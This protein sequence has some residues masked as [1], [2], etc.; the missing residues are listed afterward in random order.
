[1]DINKNQQVNTFLK[2][3]NTDISDSL[4]DSSQYRYAENLRLITNTDSNSG[5]LRLIEGT[6]EILKNVFSGESIIYIGSIRNYLYVITYKSYPIPTISP[7]WSIYVNKDYGT[8]DFESGFRCI[9]GP[10]ETP[11]WK[12][13]TNIALSTETRWE[14]DNNIKLYIADNTSEHG[15]ISINIDYDHWPSE[16]NVPSDIK[17][18]T[19]YQNMFLQAPI[20]NISQYAGNIVPAKVQYAY[21]LYKNGGAASSISTLS[22]VLSIYKT[23]KKGYSDKEISNKAVDI[24]INVHDIVGLNSI[25]IYRISYIQNGQQPTVH[26]IVNEKNTSF[27]FTYVDRGTNI[28]QISMSELLGMIQNPIQPQIIE[29]KDDYLF[30]ANLS[31]NQDYVDKKIKEC[32]FDAISVS[33]GNYWIDNNGDRQDIQ[34]NSQSGKLVNKLEDGWKLCHDQFDGS[35]S[36]DYNETYW[37]TYAQNVHVNNYVVDGRNYGGTGSN[38]SWSYITDNFITLDVNSGY[39]QKIM[40]SGFKHDETYRFGIIL[41]DEK[42]NQSSVNWIADIRIPS[43]CAKDQGNNSNYT[44]CPFGNDIIITPTYDSNT[45][46]TGVQYSVR[47]YGIKFTVR[48]LPDWCSGFQIVRCPRTL[49]DSRVISQGITY[50]PMRN[51]YGSSDDV[52]F[53]SSDY[54]TNYIAPSGFVTMQ[55]SVARHGMYFPEEKYGAAYSTDNVV[56]FA[57]PEYVYQPDDIKDILD[58][59]SN[60][61]NIEHVASY[62][63]FSKYY[64]GY[65]SIETWQNST[66][67]Y[68]LRL[69]TISAANNNTEIDILEWRGRD[70]SNLIKVE[71]VEDKPGYI[72]FNHVVPAAINNQLDQDNE[73]EVVTYPE[74]KRTAFPEVPKYNSFSDGKNITFRNASTTLGSDEFINWSYAPYLQDPYGS[75]SSMAK[76]LS[77]YHENDE[78]GHFYYPIG[79]G[80][81]CILF[82]FNEKIQFGTTSKSNEYLYKPVD[83]ES[84]TVYGHVAPIHIAN[85]VKQVYPY[86]GYNAHAINNSSYN[87]YGDVYINTHEPI[88]AEITSGDSYASLFVYNA[89]HTWDDPKYITATQNATVCIV[90]IESDIDLRASYGD[91]YDPN[92]NK[93]YYFQ[94]E[95]VSFKG[96]SQTKP[97]Y[98]YNTAYNQIPNVVTLSPAEYTDISSNKFDTRIHYSQ[99]KTNGESIDNW[100]QFKALDFI[101]VDSKFGEITQMQLFKNKLIFWQDESIGML[102]VND[103]TIINSTDND[104]IVLG[105]TGILQRY[106]YISTK[107]GMKPYQFANAQSDTTLYWWDGYAKELLGFDSQ[108]IIPL[109]TTKQIKNYINSGEE[110]TRPSLFYDAKY[111]ELVSHIL[112]KN[113][114]VYNEQIQAFTSIYGN[115]VFTF[116]PTV[117][118][119]INNDILLCAGN[120]IY[121]YNDSDVEGQAFLFDNVA[122]PYLK[123]IVNNQ[124]T[125]NKVFDITTFGGN[126]YG[127]EDVLTQNNDN[128]HLVIGEFDNLKLAPLQ[129]KFKTSLNQ[130]GIITG[131]NITNREC[132]YRFDIPRD[133]FKGNTNPRQYF[134]SSEDWGNRLRGKIMQCELTS[135]SN[136]T[137]FSLQYIITK[138]RMSWS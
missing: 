58:T 116:N 104:Q 45:V 65:S 35:S 109:S 6:K 32:G 12:D 39:D 60:N 121:R 89:S 72:A 83:N 73:Q 122:R 84:Y 25:E 91:L 75:D 117:N 62:H 26:M 103:K 86:G 120:S 28:H 106:D 42:G 11:I 125:N 93:G 130:T 52:W 41:Y 98:Q 16:T 34:I 105:G 133:N 59:Y 70:G 29:S 46:L 3:M 131:S 49:Q 55:K 66:N 17:V 94:D 137:D 56:C 1:M 101:D 74:I 96:Y 5:E 100:L 21:R 80:G 90:P 36:Y 132:D 135:S 20:V 126:I 138:Y 87:Q 123:Y 118:T 110:A 10:C 78:Y 19:G 51:L 8:N 68:R 37:H 38:I 33:S 18:L 23:D 22:N 81:K 27:P 99:L 129:F 111:K 15:I 14:S 48:D 63:I 67:G 2:G 71:D 102:T 54:E 31:Y 134:N 77:E 57:S 76:A 119:E 97:A 24:Q 124:N 64:S 44:K 114:V 107:Y 13:I 40:H 112:K 136:S 61:I 127:T 88:E 50:L 7:T 79:T 128:K 53:F 108:S 4:I 92:N 113:A 95:P 47:E 85:L 43:F 30:A 82:G 9:F 115:D 69:Q